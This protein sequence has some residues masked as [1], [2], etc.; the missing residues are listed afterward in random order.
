MSAIVSLE[1]LVPGGRPCPVAPGRVIDRFPT[2]EPWCV[3]WHP[4][5]GEPVQSVYFEPN[6]LERNPR[7]SFRL[8]VKPCQS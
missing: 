3:A 6:G 7:G 5:N 1:L 4:R 2:G 8:R